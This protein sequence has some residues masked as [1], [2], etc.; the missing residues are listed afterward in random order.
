[1]S[2]PICRWRNPYI[3][4]VREFISLLPKNEMSSEDFRQ[5]IQGRY[6][7]DFFRTPYQLAC[8]LG[9]YIE[10][11]ERY[12]PRF[13]TNIDIVELNG[14][15]KNWLKKYPVPNPYTRQGF[16]NLQPQSVHSQLCN[17][18]LD[19]NTQVDWNE[20]KNSV[21]GEEIGNDDI[22]INTINTYSDVIEI[23]SGILKMKDGVVSDDLAKF[24]IDTKLTDR[25]NKESFF[26]LFDTNDYYVFEKG[27]T[28]LRH[29]LQNNYLDFISD[30]KNSNITFDKGLVIRFISSIFT[31]PFVILTGLSGSGKT[32]LAQAFAMWIC[33]DKS[34]YC[35]VPVGADWTNREPLLGFPNALEPNKYVKPETGVLELLIEASKPENEKKPYFLILDEMNLSHVE[36]YFA[37]FLSTMETADDITL[38]SGENDWEGVSPKIKL[39]KNLFIIGTV[40]IDETTYMFSPK[41]LDRANVI[42]FRVTKEEMEIYLKDPKKIELSEI[43]SKG[44]DMAES[45]VQLAGDSIEF[46]DAAVLNKSLLDFFDELQ[47]AGAEFGYRTAGEIC[48][49]AGIIKKLDNS[50]STEEIIDIAIMQKLLPKLHGSR[51]KLIDVL[52]T[53]AGFCLIDKSKTDEFLKNSDF[54]K[55]QIIYTV[56]AEKIRRMHIN[57]INNGFTSYAEL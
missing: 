56:S 26:N 43:K 17:I 5:F 13:S 47:K 1:M 54:P 45:F 25:N 57:L 21:F 16:E 28:V 4:T 12:I 49:F 36:R 27:S 19:K 41:V 18:V 6:D 31:K 14:Y 53:L 23:R 7:G 42:E 40:N 46:E 30:L 35:I 55:E 38:H 3:K 29:K 33:E 10:I 51:R 39:P 48:R 22:L 32:K 52:K 2:D 50:L 8:Q 9:L 24:V 11:N 15:L 34:Q 44:K 20:A 37:D